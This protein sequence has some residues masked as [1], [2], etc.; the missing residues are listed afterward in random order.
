MCRDSNSYLCHYLR[1]V[2]RVP[3]GL[4]LGRAIGGCETTGPPILI[5][6]CPMQDQHGLHSKSGVVIAL[7]AM[8]QVFKPLIL[9]SLSYIHHPHLRLSCTACVR[10]HVALLG[11]HAV[12][13]PM[14]C[15]S[16]IQCFKIPCLCSQQ[17]RPAIQPVAV[18]PG[19]MLFPCSLMD[20]TVFQEHADNWQSLA[21]KQAPLR[22]HDN[23]LNAGS[24]V[25]SVHLINPTN[26]SN[27]LIQVINAHTDTAERVGTCSVSWPVSIIIA[28]N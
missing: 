13:S 12:P 9:A 4:L 21:V 20:M 16:C 18:R 27:E 6:G 15:L 25:G 22:N 14:S 28:A 5:D 10:Y 7:Q 24:S 8:S 1:E 3:D 2:Q 23:F 19:L 11:Q 26:S 17:A